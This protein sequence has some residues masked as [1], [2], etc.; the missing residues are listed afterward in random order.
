MR[1]GARPSRPLGTRLTPCGQAGGVRAPSPRDRVAGRFPDSRASSLPSF[2]RSFPLH[3]ELAPFAARWVPP[4]GRVR[5][6]SQ[7]EVRRPRVWGLDAGLSF[8]QTVPRSPAS[9]APALRR[10]KV[11]PDGAVLLLASLQSS[12]PRSFRRTLTQQRGRRPAL[13]PSPPPAAPASPEAR[14]HGSQR[15]VGSVG[16]W[17]PPAGRTASPPARTSPPSPGT[18]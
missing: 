13:S 16:L 17:P 3:S 11:T 1:P 5:G 12:S 9:R 18:V 10:T 15:R 14:R 8:R 4:P 2:H 7:S 6:P